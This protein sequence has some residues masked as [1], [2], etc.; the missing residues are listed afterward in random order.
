MLTRLVMNSVFLSV[1][2]YKTE[3]KSDYVGLYNYL[4][5]PETTSFLYGLAAD[6]ARRMNLTSTKKLFFST[7]YFFMPLCWQM[8]Y[9]TSPRFLY[10]YLLPLSLFS[11]FSQP[12]LPSQGRST[13]L[14]FCRPF[15]NRHKTLHYHGSHSVLVNNYYNKDSSIIDRAPKSK[16]HGWLMRLMEIPHYTHG[17]GGQDGVVINVN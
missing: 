11:T 17:G 6:A 3:A 9:L 2:L 12:F 13:V 14:L 4:F 16:G 8:A 10:T 5:M 1:G 7:S 15:Q